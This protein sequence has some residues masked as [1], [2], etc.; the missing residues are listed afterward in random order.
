MG[1]HVEGFTIYAVDFDGTLCEQRFPDIGRPNEALINWLVERRKTGDKVILWTNRVGRYLE[2]AVKWCNDRGLFFDA[3]NENIPE[4][5]E[6]Y[7]DF[8]DGG[9]PSP[10]ITADIF[11]DDAACGVGF[12]FGNSGCS[13][14]N[15]WNRSCE[16]YTADE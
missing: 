12:P 7:K 9:K 3:V 11:I 10:K 13:I 6:Q 8:L 16:H 5:V 2:A 1:M 14:K 15:C 4:S